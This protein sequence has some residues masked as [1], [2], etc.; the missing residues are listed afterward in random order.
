[1]I[2]N[3]DNNREEITTDQEKC[4]S[5]LKVSEKIRYVGIIN[6]FGRTITGKLKNGIR[7]ILTPEQARDERYIEASRRQLRKALEISIGKSIFT[8]EKNENVT[9]LLIP[10]TTRDIFYYITIE[11]DT[12]LTEINEIITKIVEK[13]NR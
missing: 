5:L 6:K 1:M 13:I 10:D 2:E 7:P 8:I 11:R 9:F 3:K 12:T 4:V